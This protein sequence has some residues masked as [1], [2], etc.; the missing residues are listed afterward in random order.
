MHF[1]AGAISR[2]P[3][4]CLVLSLDM[5]GRLSRVRVTRVRVLVALFGR[6]RAHRG[7]EDLAVL[8]VARQR[9]RGSVHHHG[10]DD[11]LTE[12]GDCVT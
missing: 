8:Q 1:A 4:V 5:G 7:T 11:D 2:V 12:S 6:H 9:F 10:P 3:R